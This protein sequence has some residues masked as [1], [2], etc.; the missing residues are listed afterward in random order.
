MKDKYEEYYQRMLK[1]LEISISNKDYDFLLD[2][3]DKLG[4]L[5]AKAGQYMS[6][7][8]YKIDEVIDIECQVNMQLLDKYSAST[9]N[10]MIK[11]KAKDWTRL[12]IGFERCCS[13]AV[14]QIDAI[15]TIIS[16]EK[17]KMN[18]V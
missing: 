7:C 15:R 14:H 11:A 4:I 8:Q 12:K 16:F 2:R 13:T 3:L 1:Y 18:L 10:M 17:A 9:F 5:L 6:E